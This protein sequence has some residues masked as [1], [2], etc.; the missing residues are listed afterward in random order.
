VL[1]TWKS[2]D[3]IA[4]GVEGCLFI[5][6]K[7]KFACNTGQEMFYGLFSLAVTTQEALHAN[8]RRKSIKSERRKFKK[9]V[10][11][12]KN[13]SVIGGSNPRVFRGFP[14]SIRDRHFGHNASYY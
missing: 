14:H 4:S 8:Q 11:T 3:K 10:R 12:S 7:G 9:S 13:I 5:I 1:S 2:R 6:K